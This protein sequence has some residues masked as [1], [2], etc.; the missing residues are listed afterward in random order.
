MHVC[1]HVRTT[2]GSRLRFNRRS[3]HT[4]GTVL[5]RPRVRGQTQPP[6]AQTTALN[7]WTNLGTIT[8]VLFLFVL[9]D[10]GGG[11]ADDDDDD[12]DGL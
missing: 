10:G 6:V 9:D 2:G 4:R 1:T 5:P 12:N 8:V 7:F 3:I 11:D